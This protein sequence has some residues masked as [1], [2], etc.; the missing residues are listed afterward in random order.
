MKVAV[1]QPYLFPYL[2]Y[3]QMVKASDIFVFY[4]NVDYIQ[5]GYINR[6]NMWS[7]NGKQYF[8]VPVNK[9]RLGTKINEVLIRDFDTW[10]TKFLKQLR[11]TYAKAPF[12]NPTYELLERFLEQKKYEKISDLS[13]DSVRMICNCL[14]LHN[15]F[16]LSSEIEG[17]TEI[18][19]KGDK[20]DYILTH[21][22]AREIILPPGSTE[23][24]KH[25]KP[26]NAKKR[27]LEIPEINYKQFNF[28]FIE[29]LSII[30]VLMFNA[31]EN[32]L[33]F[34]EKV[35]YQ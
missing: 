7:S 1:M 4:D 20:L 29:H 17:L 14:G 35:N 9:S 16:A 27:T 5:R 2:G 18:K 12:F 25:W 32:V 15:Q 26:E 33:S 21:Y 8:T 34:V 11:F 22:K 24:Y 10:K 6:N 3:F 19:D 13:S 23:L 30:D 28:Q 31:L